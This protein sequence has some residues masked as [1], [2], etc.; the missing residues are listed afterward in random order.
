LK[1]L[2]RNDKN[3][4]WKLVESAAYE[5]EDELQKI[6]AKSPSLISIEDVRV[7]A[8]Q[9]VVAVR[10]FPLPIGS[11]DLVAFSANGDI[12]LIE[13]KLASNPEIKRK[14]IGQALEY[15]A[16]LWQMR[17]EDLDQKI[18]ERTNRSL[19]DLMHAAL[20]DIEWDEEAFRANVESSLNA[21]SFILMIVVD[22]ITEE[23]SRIIHFVNN[24]GLPVFT[25]A[26]LEMQ[27]YQSE[28]TEMLVPRVVGDTFAPAGGDAGSRTRW[29]EN[30]F[31]TDAAKKL[32]PETLQTITRLYDWS[33]KNSNLVRFGTGSANGS[34]TFLLERDGVTGSIFS[35]F[36][37]G[38]MIV[39]FGYMEKI[40][41]SEEIAN[42]RKELSTISTFGNILDSTTYYYTVKIA[43][44]FPKQ[45][46]VERFQEIVL[47]L[48]K[49]LEG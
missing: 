27:R 25:F 6:I 33:G 32:D 11:L 39:N 30:T 16:Y 29:T 35:V 47:G 34:F 48:K 49:L 1:I 18:K 19:A 17:Y 43:S 8:G 45:E 31:F 2:L 7:G 36:T 23:L 37:Y 13:C 5:G 3:G 44:V 24:C 26:A 22:K 12:T 41:S 42:F 20:G 10:E 14:V 4:A 15:G 28:Q 38:V 21:G 46:Y 9:L 40:F